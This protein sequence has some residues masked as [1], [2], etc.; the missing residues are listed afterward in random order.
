MT[1]DLSEKNPVGYL[2]QIVAISGP[3]E[4]VGGHFDVKDLLPG[5]PFVAPGDDVVGAH[6]MTRA[7][8]EALRR[9]GGNSCNV[10]LFCFSLTALYFFVS[11]LFFF[12]L[13][14]VIFHIFILFMGHFVI[15]LF[16]SF[17]L[18]TL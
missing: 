7:R 6:L 15:Y 1:S 13:D 11:G 18:T 12:I 5:G 9:G 4:S 16:Y 17:S 8:R 2:T 3:E 14:T 10:Q